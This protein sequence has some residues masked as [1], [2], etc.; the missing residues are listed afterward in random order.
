MQKD[1]QKDLQKG[2]VMTSAPIIRAEHLVKSFGFFRR[3]T[4]VIDVSLEVQSQEIVGLLGSNGAGKST[5]FDMLSGLTHPTAG[6]IFQYEEEGKN[7]RNITKDPLYK[8]AQHGIC[9]L[10]QK[11][12]VFASLTARENLLGIMEIMDARDLKKSMLARNPDLKTR[13]DFCEDLLHEFELYERRDS[14]A[15]H[16]SGGEQRRLEIARSFIRRPRLILMDEPYNALDAEMIDRCGKLFRALRNGGVSFL[17]I[18]HRI[19]QILKICDRVI[20]LNKGCVDFNGDPFEF[21]KLPEAQVLL[22]PYGNQ[23]AELFRNYV[24]RQPGVSDRTPSAAVSARSSD[25][26]VSVHIE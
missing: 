5:T 7:W 6:S 23:I 4:P 3:I 1:S 10:S 9:Y 20:F 2:A 8:R 24:P 15:K 12:S 13:E 11:P 21:T 22:Q 14:K 18:D 26:S 17:I 16:L 19:D 25:S